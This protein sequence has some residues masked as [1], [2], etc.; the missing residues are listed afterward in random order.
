MKI[1]AFLFFVGLAAVILHFAKPG[2]LPQDVA[3]VAGLLLMGIF[4]AL[5]VLWIIKENK[6]IPAVETLKANVESLVEA[7]PEILYLFEDGWDV[8][9]I[10]DMI[11]ANYQLP[12]KSV[13]E[14]VMELMANRQK[15]LDNS[16]R[17][18]SPFAGP[19][20]DRAKT[21]HSSGDMEIY[22]GNI[23]ED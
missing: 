11:S 9:R 15:E 10:V 4:G 20:K 19:D 14:H 1:K 22:Y 7:T 3:L 2:L 12:P 16:Q 23:K 17:V 21:E 6:N 18:S 5:I 13:Y 8:K